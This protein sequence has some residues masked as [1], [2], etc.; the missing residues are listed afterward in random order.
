MARHP[1][2]IRPLMMSRGRDSTELFESYHSLSDSPRNILKKFAVPSK[3]LKNY[4]SM[5]NWD[6]DAPENAFQ[7]ELRQLVREHVSKNKIDTM[8]PTH[9]LVA[10][11]VWTALT[12]Y[13][14][15]KY[16]WAGEWWSMLVV[17]TMWWISFVHTFHD[18]SH[19]ALSKNEFITAL[20]VY[21][22][23]FFSSPTTWEH[24]HVIGHHV[25]TNIFKKDPDLNH[26]IP[27]FRLHTRFRYRVW[28]QFQMLWVWVIW[29]IS[30]FW[31]S[32][33][34][35]WTGVTTGVYHGILPYKKFGNIGMGLHL[36]GRAVS[37]FFTF[38][39]P[40]TLFD[41]FGKALMWTV[42]FYSVWGFFFMLITQVNHIT[43][44]CVEAG[45]E[46]NECWAIH[47]VQTS[48]DYAH[49]SN[50]WWLLSAGLNLQ[51]EHHL[52]PGINN[53]HLIG[54]SPIVQSLCKKYGVKYN[55]SPTYLEAIT[56]YLR[57]VQ[58]GATDNSKK[59]ND[60]KKT[61]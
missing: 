56:K 12:I 28:M 47:Q 11:L 17:P 38:G 31:L 52:F 44:D 43:E 29:F 36:F 51:I 37:F 48:H 53:N 23:P 1:G 13:C 3:N 18:A 7:K 57:V 10:N 16:Y 4:V 30:T 6:M 59:A 40:F 2:G 54:I 20:F 55:Y 61:A 26:G 60:S 19:F 50:F 22:Y 33:V 41:S 14:T 5:F 25:Y 58:I 15:Y 49:H 9:L 46:P 39:I 42:S 24:Q 32:T 21:I 27:Y 8:C 35:D 34:Y 45:A